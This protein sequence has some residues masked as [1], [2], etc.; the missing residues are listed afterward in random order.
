[1]GLSICNR[2]L[3]FLSRFRPR[4]DTSWPFRDNTKIIFQKFLIQ[5]SHNLSPETL[6]QSDTVGH[7]RW[8]GS[9]T[10]QNNSQK[11]NNIW[12]ETRRLIRFY[13]PNFRL[14]CYGIRNPILSNIAYFGVDL[15]E[16]L[17]LV[18]ISYSGVTNQNL[19][20]FCFQRKSNRENEDEANTQSNA[21]ILLDKQFKFVKKPK[22]WKS[23]QFASKS[24]LQSFPTSGI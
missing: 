6:S 21:F 4:G 8:W 7:R 10:A 5:I 22:S 18:A 14:F 16:W 9:W 2:D 1:M 12:W 20:P 23:I 11:L 13:S 3:Q 17:H 19:F 24:E 15:R